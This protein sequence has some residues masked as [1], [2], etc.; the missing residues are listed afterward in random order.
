ML[1]EEQKSDRYA[2]FSEP[3]FATSIPMI[4]TWGK[5]TKS[6]KTTFEN[7]KPY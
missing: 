7:N 1:P 2:M 3:V 4:L 5:D 6:T